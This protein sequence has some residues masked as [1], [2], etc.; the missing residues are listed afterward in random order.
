MH[1]RFSEFTILVCTRL[2]CAVFCRLPSAR[3]PANRSGRPSADP[4]GSRTRA[5]AE[6]KWNMPRH[7]TANS[8]RAGAVTQALVER[9]GVESAKTAFSAWRIRSFP[10]LNRGKENSVHLNTAC[11]P[12]RY[13]QR[14]RLDFNLQRA[15]STFP[16]HAA[17]PL[18]DVDGPRFGPEGVRRW[19]RH[20]RVLSS[21]SAMF[22]QLPCF[23]VQRL[24]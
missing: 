21:F 9:L 13:E 4:Q 19:R 8:G 11:I 20:C 5:Y 3:R 15:S 10:Y 6:Q 23:G 2:R 14:K 16:V 12:K 18:V 24:A 17:L 7:R 22:S 1:C